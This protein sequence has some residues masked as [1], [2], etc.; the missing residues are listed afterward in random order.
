M[1]NCHPRLSSEFCG[2]EGVYTQKARNYSIL[3]R[4][5]TE[6]FSSDINNRSRAKRPKLLIIDTFSDFFDDAKDPTYED[7]FERGKHLREISLLL[8]RLAATHHI[9]VVLL[10]EARPTYVRIEGHD[11]GPGELLYTD[12]ERW[13]SRAHSIPGEDAHESALGLVWPNQ[14]NARIMMSRTART[15]PRTEVDPRARSS[16]SS[17]NGDGERAGKRIRL[18][19]GPLD[20]P[21]PFRRLSVIFS[22]VAPTASC[23]YVVLDQGVVGFAVVEPPP[24]TF[25]YPTP[26][27]P[28]PSSAPATQAH[29]ITTASRLSQGPSTPSHHTLPSSASGSS[30]PT[31]AAEASQPSTSTPYALALSSPPSTSPLHA[32]TPAIP[33]EDMQDDDEELYWRHTQVDDHV[34]SKFADQLEAILPMTAASAT[35][36]EEDAED[37]PLPDELEVDDGGGHASSDSEHYWNDAD[38]NIDW[39][40]I[41]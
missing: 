21:I 13:F 14:V 7:R 37:G 11:N 3:V 38:G 15:R 5:L 39:T 8:H 40:N 23:D 27:P 1:V 24:S 31:S 19:T 33:S 30:D 29:V 9:A 17:S 20:E 16:Y 12:Q 26:T 25:M 35:E 10:S 28:P 6:M 32:T 22:S 4:L 34:F 41:P 36:V 18:D 2:L